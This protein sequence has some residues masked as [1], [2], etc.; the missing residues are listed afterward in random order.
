MAGFTLLELIVVL[1]I[2]T[3]ITSAVVPVFSSSMATIQLR[4]AQNNFVSTL[5]FVQERAVSESLEYRLYIDDD[6]GCYWV[7]ALEGFEDDEE[8]F[9]QVES[10]FGQVQYL[11]AFMKIDRLKARE[12]RA[13]RAKFIGCYPNGACDRASFILQDTRGRDRRIEIETLGSLGKI[14]AKR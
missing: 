12:D 13:R 8:V 5:V 10:S 1:S 11:P 4:S 9:S 2:L 6:E 7:M 14:R 3:I